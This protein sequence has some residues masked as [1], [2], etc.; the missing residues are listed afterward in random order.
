VRICGVRGKRRV[1]RS[2]GTAAPATRRWRAPLQDALLRHLCAAARAP[3]GG[4][5]AA[6]AARL[7][8]RAATLPVPPSSRLS[9][10][11]HY[12]LAPGVLGLRQVR[13]TFLPVRSSLASDVA[14]ST[15]HHALGAFVTTAC[16]ASACCFHSSAAAFFAANVIPRVAANSRTYAAGRTLAL[17]VW[18][19]GLAIIGGTRY[20]WRRHS[21]A[22]R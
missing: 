9:R 5:A 8:T 21:A 20:R 22:L 2:D 15:F 4:R 6:L 7:R 18:A 14:F 3:L 17:K 19:T 1:R 10:T 16:S 13:A 11:L 12:F